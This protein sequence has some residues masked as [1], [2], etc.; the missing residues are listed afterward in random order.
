MHRS[1]R[2]FSTAPVTSRDARARAGAACFRAE[3]VAPVFSV[4][5]GL[6]LA[7]A[8]PLHAATILASDFPPSFTT[9]V[10]TFPDVL[11]GVNATFAVTAPSG[12]LFQTNTVEGVVGVGPHPTTGAEINVGEVVTASFSQP[13]RIAQIG[14]AFLFDGPEFGDPQEIAQIT[15]NGAITGQLAT[16]FATQSALWSVPSLSLSFDVEPTSPPVSPGGAG[17]WL[18]DDPFGDTPVQSLVFT[19]VLGPCA[20]GFSCFSD[21]DYAIARVTLVPEASPA[22]L[23]MA[24]VSLLA[25]SKCVRARDVARI[26]GDPG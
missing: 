4:I 20:P 23:L 14:V 22:L 5:F 9:A 13:V 10:A 17:L 11:P 25:W 24:G 8:R 7:F 26:R 1:Q 15:A 18:V 2:R 3:R 6:A 19:A 12:G 21:A 16:D